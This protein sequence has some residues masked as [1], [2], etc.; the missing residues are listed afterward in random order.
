MRPSRKS[1]RLWAER[2]ESHLKRTRNPFAQSAGD[3]VERPRQHP[4]P[5][6]HAPTARQALRV[7]AIGYGRPA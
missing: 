7:R 3:A 1:G 4:P 5:S 2:G 6:A